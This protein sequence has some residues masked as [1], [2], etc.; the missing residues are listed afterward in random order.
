MLK[1]INIVPYINTLNVRV[2]ISA[3]ARMCACAHVCV[4]IRINLI[5]MILSKFLLPLM[6]ILQ[7]K[8]HPYFSFYSRG[9]SKS[10]LY[11]DVVSPSSI[12][13][14]SRNIK[15]RKYWNIMELFFI[16]DYIDIIQTTKAES[17]Q[18]IKGRDWKDVMY[19]YICYICLMSQPVTRLSQI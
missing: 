10:F 15:E 4:S 12:S 3:R 14:V 8:H 13:I 5:I 1:S 9:Y 19:H 16:L 18:R 17:E 2:S 7:D 11:R 6:V